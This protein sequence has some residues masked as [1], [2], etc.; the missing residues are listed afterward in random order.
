[1]WTLEVIKLNDLA[2]VAGGKQKVRGTRYRL[3]EN[4]QVR[5]LGFASWNQI[6][7]NE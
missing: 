2:G 4:R 3:D 5:L 1:M 7:L 6:A